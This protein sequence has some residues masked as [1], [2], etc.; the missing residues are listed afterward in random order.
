MRPERIRHST[1]ERHPPYALSLS[2]AALEGAV[3]RD[4]LTPELS[5]LIAAARM[6]TADVQVLSQ[7]QGSVTDAL[8]DDA[9][10][11]P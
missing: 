1:G 9:I 2:L 5:R 7:A 8:Q 4:A 3:S 10:E 11:H 6:L